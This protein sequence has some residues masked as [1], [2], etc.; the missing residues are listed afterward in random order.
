MHVVVNEKLISTRVK[1]ASAAHL[2][3]LAVFAVGLFISWSNPEPT[4]EQ[5]AG[6]YTA[7]I[8]GLVLYNV[9]QFFL[10][11]FGPR[12]R[13]EGVLSKTLKGLDRRY[14]LLAFPSTKLP[15]YILVGPGGVQVVVARA[16]DGAISYRGG[17]WSRDAGSG[18]KRLSGLFGGT[19]FGDPTKDLEKGVTRVREKLDKAGISGAKQ[20]PV[21][22]VVV[23]TNPAAR[24]RIDGSS[25]PVTGL[26]GLRNS[27]R[28]G[29]GARER[30]LDERS[31]E[32]VVQAL[33]G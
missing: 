18:L 22:G 10:R 2:A 12:S 7:I 19:P 13:V 26:K 23:F 21:E 17:Q 1:I 29:K 32:R 30:A 33:R 8:V 20:P 9:G 6:A 28:G 27:V 16:H 14:T 31:A 24:L 4:Y 5:M 15:D 25:Y 11:R 3:A